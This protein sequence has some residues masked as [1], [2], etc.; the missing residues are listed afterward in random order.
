MDESTSLILV[1]AA[2]IRRGHEI[3][4][5]Q[6]PA[7]GWGAGRWE[8][9]GG[10][11]EPGEQPREA[12]A[13]ECREEL[14]VEI[15]VRTPIDLIAHTYPDG[16]SVTLAFFDAVLVDPAAEP[17]ALEG[18]ALEWSGGAALLAYDWLEADWP[19]VERLAIETPYL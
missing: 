19:I 3:L 18:G 11:V 15:E 7:G 6:R 13:R 12:L 10:K 9:P 5:H 14:G 2:V 4:L 1:V 17:R 8:F 16:K